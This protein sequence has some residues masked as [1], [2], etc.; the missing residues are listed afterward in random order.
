MTHPATSTANPPPN[1]WMQLLAGVAGMVAVANLQYGW[2]F[3]VG[4]LGEKHPSWSEK[5]IQVAFTLFV[6]AETWLVPIEAFLADLFGPR[7]LV[8]AGGVLAAGGW[9]LNALAD[10]LA[11]LYLGNILAGMGAGIVYGISIGSAL[12]WFPDRR[13]LAAGVTAAAF[14]AGSALTVAPLRY[15]IRVAGYQA[16][17]LWFGLGQGLIVLAVALV[18]RTPRPAELARVAASPVEQSGR[19]F[20]P[21]EMLATPTFW[22]LYVMMTMVTVGGLMAMAQLEPMARSY[23]IAEERL[24]FFGLS[25]TVLTLTASS[26]RILN[27]LTRPFFGWVSDRIG[28]ERTMFIA[29][30]LEACA[31]ALL[32]NLAAHPVWFV[33]L[34]GL[35]FFGWGEIYSLFPAVSGDLF[36]RRYATTNYALLYTAKGTASLLVPLGSYLH[37]QTG[38]WKPIFAL[39]IVFDL[40][41]AILAVTALR[42]LRRRTRAGATHD[43]P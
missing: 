31:I 9:V 19:D 21:L 5:S 17:F 35:T 27:G 41:T 33:L 30:T 10:R 29:F 22:L 14:G 3:F 12:R 11:V 28:R 40:L 16:A 43:K 26:E 24:P 6:L 8:A 23:G 18:L 42:W 4:P 38:S 37:E 2:T 39:A 36:G 13:G 15:T 25:V 34:M 7:R 32:V 1:R 20:T